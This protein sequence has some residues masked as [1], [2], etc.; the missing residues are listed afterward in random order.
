MVL[1]YCIPAECLLLC[2][3]FELFPFC[4]SA[5]MPRTRKFN[6]EK[7]IQK[8]NKVELKFLHTALPLLVL[9]HFRKSDIFI[10]LLKT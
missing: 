9:C 4:I 1:R 8:V 10:F 7:I 2:I 3:E 6:K 5:V